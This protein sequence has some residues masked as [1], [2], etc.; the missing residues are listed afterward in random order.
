MSNNTRKAN[1]ASDEIPEESVIQKENLLNKMSFALYGTSAVNSNLQKDLFNFRKV[2][3]DNVVSEQSIK[4]WLDLETDTA[5]ERA[6]SFA[7]LHDFFMQAPQNLA[8]MIEGRK[9][10]YNQV[11]SFLAKKKYRTE[12]KGKGNPRPLA[13]YKLAKD[14]I[15]IRNEVENKDLVEFADSWTGI[16]CS[17]RLRLIKNIKKPF[18][19]EVISI[20]RTSTAILYKHWHLQDGQQL[21]YFEG[22]VLIKSDT[23]WMLGVKPP[24]NRMR[25][26]H[27]KKANSPN[28]TN[29]KI[30]W[31][32]MHSDVPEQVSVEPASTRILLIKQNKKINEAEFVKNNVQYLASNDLPDKFRELI[33]RMTANQTS[34]FSLDDSVTPQENTDHILRVDQR[35]IQNA[36]TSFADE[37]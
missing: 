6:K 25:L 9:K 36:C 16:Y 14:G 7:F 20:R 3:G 29:T 23:V 19:S 5:P 28:P 17:Y 30:R 2:G 22:G 21:S 26:C 35:T 32:L 12:K 13:S 15:F 8:N 33:I 34:A 24:N 11:R 27:F 37:E 4:N 31:G 1:S 18:A 10:V